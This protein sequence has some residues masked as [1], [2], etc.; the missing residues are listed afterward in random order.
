MISI[1]QKAF[2]FEKTDTETVWHVYKRPPS[3]FKVPLRQPVA[4]DPN[5]IKPHDLHEAGILKGDLVEINRFSGSVV[6]CTEAV[7][8]ALL[9]KKGDKL[10][11]KYH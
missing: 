11:P 7:A 3:T 10:V 1:L 5:W 6:S 4:L 9:R 8:N 2:N